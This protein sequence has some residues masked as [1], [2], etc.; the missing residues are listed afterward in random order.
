MGKTNWPIGVDAHIIGPSMTEQVAHAPQLIV[1]R[2]AR[3]Q[4]DA[5]DTTHL[6]YPSG[7]RCPSC[8]SAAPG[9]SRWRVKGQTLHARGP[10]DARVLG[11]EGEE[12]GDGRDLQARSIPLAP[13]VGREPEGKQVLLATRLQGVPTRGRLQQI[14]RA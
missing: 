4:I 7:G 3:P 13:A 6:D 1:T 5:S 2:R 12:G 11:D 14:A 8:R 9:R 10:H